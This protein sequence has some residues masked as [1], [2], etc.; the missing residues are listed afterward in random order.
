[1]RVPVTV[2]GG[3]AVGLT[4]SLLLR[5]FRVPHMVLEKA[6]QGTQHPQAHYLNTRTMEVL[7]SISPALQAAVEARSPEVAMWRNFVY[8]TDLCHLSHSL[9]GRVDHMSEDS[10]ASMSPCRQLHVPQHHFVDALTQF[11]SAYDNR[12]DSAEHTIRYEHEVVGLEGRRLL[13]QNTASKETACIETDTVIAC[14]GAH[15]F[16]RNQYTDIG[17]QSDTSHVH[18]LINVHFKSQQLASVLQQDP[19][20]LYFVF[21]RRSVVVIVAH[22]LENGEFVAQIP[23]WSP[24][25]HSDFDIGTC[26]GLLMEA[27]HG[28]SAEVSRKIRGTRISDLQI[29]S[30]NPWT[31]RG[32]VASRY[33]H[34]SNND[35]DSSTIVLCGDAAHQFPPAGGFGLNT[36][37]QDAHALVWRLASGADL[38]DYSRERSEIAR[39]N[40]MQSLRNF[41]AA[42][43]VPETMGLHKR[44]AGVLSDALD[45]LPLPSFVKTQLWQQATKLGL[46]VTRVI[47]PPAPEV[48]AA[49]REHFC[50]FQEKT[51]SKLPKPHKS[52]K[53]SFSLAESGGFGAVRYVRESAGAAATH[54]ARAAR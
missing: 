52:R 38:D 13:V 46:S 4:T 36:G 41:E 24:Q 20:M 25:K 9:L 11:H 51:C 23:F 21:A 26:E 28:T 44:A 48:L 27:I 53:N 8:S 42:N 35:N 6:A 15:S 19:A 33:V 17:M 43:S 31:M 47:R 5:R 1:M 3:G 10:L 45:A 34:N 12:Q 30:A 18:S 39:R 2:V 14:D 29:L 37:V 40:L 22:D 54:A 7:R 16:V 32:Q 50:T 49:E